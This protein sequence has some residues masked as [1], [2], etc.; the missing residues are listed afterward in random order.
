MNEINLIFLVSVL[1]LCAIM[2]ISYAIYPWTQRQI[3]KIQK[4]SIRV[5]WHK[6][7]SSG[8]R[9]ILVAFVLAGLCASVVSTGVMLISSYFGVYLHGE[10]NIYVRFIETIWW[11]YTLI[12]LIF[13]IFATVNHMVESD[14]D[15]KTE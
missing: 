12:G 13:L 11:I 4:K 9:S 15:V 3:R 1:S 14:K 2:V 5:Y 6:T 10:R 8:N 7:L